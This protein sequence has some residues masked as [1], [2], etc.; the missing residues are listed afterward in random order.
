VKIRVTRQPV[1]N[2]NGINLRHYHPNRVYDLPSNLAEYLVI[3]GFGLLEMRTSQK[4]RR[5]Y[6]RPG[7]RRGA[8]FP[9]R[10]PWRV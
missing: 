8:L 1:G 2:L 6:R 9:D 5:Q 3:Q 7:E 10:F 4:D